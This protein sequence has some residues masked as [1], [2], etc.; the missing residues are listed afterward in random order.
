MKQLFEI[1][2]NVLKWGLIVT[3]TILII[4]QLTKCAVQRD[5]I[6]SKMP[7]DSVNVSQQQYGGCWEQ[8]NDST[9]RKWR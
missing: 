5:Y 4:G 2:G 7:D 3:G 9:W 8:V 1:S 6:D